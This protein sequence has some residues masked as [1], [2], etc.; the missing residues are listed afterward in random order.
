[1]FLRIR[2]GFLRVRVVFLNVRVCL[3][4]QSP[5]AMHSLAG[6]LAHH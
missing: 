5:W 6:C 1:M 3:G 2:V 4:L